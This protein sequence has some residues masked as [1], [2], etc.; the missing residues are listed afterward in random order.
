[1][2]RETVVVVAEASAALGY[3]HL[4]RAVSTGLELSETYDVQLVSRTKSA[5]E[6]VE[7]VLAWQRGNISEIHLLE[8]EPGWDNVAQLAKDVQRISDECQPICVIYDGK[9]KFAQSES[10]LPFTSA[11]FVLI[12]NPNAAGTKVDLVIFPTCHLD[13][14]LEATFEVPVCSGV[15]WTFVHPSLGSAQMP[16][17]GVP[18]GA[19]VSLGRGDPMGRLATVVESVRKATDEQLLVVPPESLDDRIRRGLDRV[20]RITWLDPGVNV[21]AALLTSRIA[22]CA[23]GISAYEAVELGV[24]LWLLTHTGELDGDASRFMDFFGDRVAG[25]GENGLESG[26]RSIP[27][28]MRPTERY[29]LGGLGKSLLNWLQGEGHYGH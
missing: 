17:T 8:G 6:I 29:G 12:D 22:V 13:P 16:L 20:G 10:G 1:M 28:V 15:P 4:V 27:T 23:F 26:L 19:F 14:T 9:F 21:A 2:R 7:E 25:F 18:S 5:H 3:G 24:P 11:K